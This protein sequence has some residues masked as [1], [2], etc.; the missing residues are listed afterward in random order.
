M[1]ETERLI[2]RRWKPSDLEPFAEINADP[3]VMQYFPSCLS[4]QESD[5]FVERIED[6]FLNH[7]FG[8]FAAELKSDSK[9]MGFMGLHVASFQA[10]FT[11]CVEIGWRIGASYWNKGFATEGALAVIG[12]AFDRLRLD[13]IV[14][15]TVP[16]N[17]ASR[18]V[19]EK[20]GMTHDPA[21]DFDHP[22]L[23]EGHR[24][25]RHVLYRLKNPNLGEGI[26]RGFRG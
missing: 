24:L 12:F 15:F 3:R 4:R 14:S 5:E 1:L 25:R 7:G 23:P 20:I 6:H 26:S 18:K 19:M 22:R 9:L 2:L 17:V 21:D 16:E 13:G 11:P 8:L 10:H